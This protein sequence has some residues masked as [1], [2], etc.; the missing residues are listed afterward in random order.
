MVKIKLS[1]LTKHFHGVISIKE[2]YNESFIYTFTSCEV[3]GQRGEKGIGKTKEFVDL[4]FF[5]R[6]I[7]TIIR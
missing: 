5:F 3:K 2:T 4:Q 7:M 6:L 1:D